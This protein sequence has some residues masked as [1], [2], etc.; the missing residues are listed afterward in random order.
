MNNK[1][2]ITK[3]ALTVAGATALYILSKAMINFAIA[4]RI[5]NDS[6][7]DYNGSSGFKLS[8]NHRMQSTD[9]YKNF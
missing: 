1:S 6:K 7:V 4:F 8:K 2:A 5:Q 9:K 3:G